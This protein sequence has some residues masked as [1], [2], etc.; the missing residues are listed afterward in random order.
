MLSNL[1]YKIT[2]D[3][4]AQAEN[5]G[6]TFSQSVTIASMIEKE[7]ANDEERSIIASVIYNRLAA[8]M[9]LQIDA[10]VQYILPERKAY[11]TDA[12][13][14]IDNPYNTYLYTG[15]P[16]GAIS[17]PGMASIKAALNP[18]DTGYY[19]YALDLETETHQFFTN[20]N[21]FQA[22]TATQ[23]YASQNT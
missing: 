4:Y 18:A 1:H 14:Q 16:P 20:Y 19:Y 13:T 23:D 11:L 2:A 6:I 15:L 10:T 5:L 21:D 22:F 3:M 17:N 8:D 7:A 12:D 9:P